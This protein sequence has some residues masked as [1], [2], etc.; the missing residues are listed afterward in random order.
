MAS[1]NCGDCGNC[2]RGLSDRRRLRRSAIFSSWSL[3]FPSDEID[4]LASKWFT[5][6]TAKR[7]VARILRD[8]GLDETCIDAEAFLLAMTEIEKFDAL[9]A[10]LELHR[11]KLLRQ[12][13]DHRAGL[14]IQVMTRLDQHAGND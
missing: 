10:K 11:D 5:N 9:K 8:F 1:T 13:E 4:D 7:R 3:M 6:K 14:A 2:R 12:I